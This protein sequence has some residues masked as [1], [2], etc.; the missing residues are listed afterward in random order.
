MKYLAAL[1]VTFG[2]L[3]VIG[4]G[5]SEEDAN[6]QAHQLLGSGP[7]VMR[8]HRGQAAKGPH[9]QQPLAPNAGAAGSQAPGTPAQGPQ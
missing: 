6:V 5:P 2:G 9:V 8:Q 7:P 1:A 4:C 3:A